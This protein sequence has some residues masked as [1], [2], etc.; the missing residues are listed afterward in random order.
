MQ[1]SKCCKKNIYI[2]YAP[3]YG[4]HYV[5]KDCGME[6]DTIHRM[7]NDQKDLNDA[8]IQQGFVL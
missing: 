5:C 1:I 4:S 7:S 3:E 6:C 2:D 8:E